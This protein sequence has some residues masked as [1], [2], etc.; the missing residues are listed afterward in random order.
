MASK[1]EDYEIIGDTQTVALLSRNGS[2]D[3]LCVRR[4][5]S[6]ACF[7]V[8]VGYDG[9]GR[10]AIRRMT[11]IREIRQQYDGNTLILV[12][13]FTCDGGK[14]PAVRL[15]AAERRALRHYPPSRLTGG[16]GV[17]PRSRARAAVRLRRKPPLRPVFG[18]VPTLQRF[19]L[20]KMWPRPRQCEQMFAAA[21]LQSYAK[22]EAA[23]CRAPLMPIG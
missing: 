22:G 3:W 10:W 4:F 9:H 23:N 1:R 14:G 21:F 12:T 5:D 19:C 15:H 17:P 6:D 7:A 16:R 20:L 18:G 8:L 2:I 13:E 11:A